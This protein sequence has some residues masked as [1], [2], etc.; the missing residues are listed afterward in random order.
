MRRPSEVSIR[1]ESLA[2]P[3]PHAGLVSGFY[4]DERAATMDSIDALG[5]LMRN[6]GS[7]LIE[8][9][10]HEAAAQ[11][12]MLGHVRQLARRRCVVFKR[13]QFRDESTQLSALNEA[14]RV[15]RFGKMTIGIQLHLSGRCS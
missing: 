11:A 4:P 13:Q 15:V 14:L 9:L 12:F 10:E 5:Y 8:L 6:A 7:R 1:A 2:L 3:G